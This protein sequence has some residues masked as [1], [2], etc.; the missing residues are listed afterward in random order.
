MKKQKDYNYTLYMENIVHDM[1]E[2][3]KYCREE[4]EV[5][6]QEVCRQKGTSGYVHREKELKE[7]LSACGVDCSMAKTDVDFTECINKVMTQQER[8]DAL[9]T[10]MHKIYEKFPTSDNYMERL[11]RR[12]GNPAYQQDSV[13][14]AILKQFI[15]ETDYC[16]KPVVEW[17]KETYNLDS[18]LKPAALQKVAAECI[19]EEVFDHL[20]SE[21]TVVEWIEVYLDKMPVVWLDQVETEETEEF[22]DYFVD[23][24]YEKDWPF[25][26]KLCWLQD[27]L[28]ASA[29]DKMVSEKVFAFLNTSEKAMRSLFYGKNAEERKPRER[30]EQR[31]KDIR[32]RKR[33]VPK[34]SI[35]KLLMLAD[36]LAAGRFREEEDLKSALYLF[37]IAFGMSVSDGEDD[38]S[39]DPVTD[40]EKNL[41][42]D[43]YQDSLLKYIS[44]DYRKNAS[45][46]E[47]EPSG[48]GINY[49]NF[50][51]TIY[52]YVLH[53]KNLTARKKI[54]LADKLIKDC[55][56]Q[57]KDRTGEAENSENLFVTE[58]YKEFFFGDILEMEEKE[59]VPFLLENY[60]I[61]ADVTAEN[62]MQIAS[63]QVTATYSCRKL[64]NDLKEEYE[65]ERI[66]FDAMNWVEMRD[67]PDV[68]KEDRDFLKVLTRMNGFLH[69]K[70]AVKDVYEHQ[71]KDYQIKFAE[72]TLTEDQKNVTRMELIAA[73]FYK[74]SLSEQGDGLSLPE[75]YDEFCSEVDPLLEQCR[76]QKI[77]VK[78]IFDMFVIFS[79][80]R[81][82]V[83]I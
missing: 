16:T 71:K 33:K 3:I 30:Y 20:D 22:L 80:Y 75:L 68:C 44:D 45:I 73:Y 34:N 31:K 59:L 35:K 12:L 15:Q 65:A 66:S 76:Y 56:K 14:L 81:I 64:I 11:V 36:D 23:K 46:L 77:N 58:I 43:F 19:G 27:Y 32:K 70:A 9:F 57:A 53:K 26:R 63:D 55:M 61:P 21:L 49:K 79:L 8:E 62:I 69:I 25:S 17:A 74:Y 83:E 24:G 28:S 50:A 42:H 37:A 82:S 52:L 48:E 1:T 60:D 6:W 47:K 18:S 7:M 5:K 72:S 67:F 40:I 54:K 2:K 29:E 13:R 38:P 78:N 10:T 51:E 39:Y 4:L 41:F